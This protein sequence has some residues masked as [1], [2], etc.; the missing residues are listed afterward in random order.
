LKIKRIIVSEV[1]PFEISKHAVL[2][3]YKRVK[4]NKGAEG[5]DEQTIVDFEANLKD[6]LYK[7]W[8]R[9]SSGTYFPPAVR[10]VEI[11]KADGKK[12]VLGIPTVGDRV[13][14]TVVKMYLE[15]FVDP[16]FHPNSYGYRPNKSATDAVG[17][18][19]KRCWAYDW[20]IDIDIKGFF[21]NMDHELVMRAVMK[22]TESK[23]IIMY[24][25]RWLKAPAMQEDGTTI[26]RTKGSPQGGVISPLIANIFMHHVFDEW[27][28]SNHSVNLFERYADDSA[29]RMPLGNAA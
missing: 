8:N 13:A 9:M 23:W 7:I 24:I 5:I 21:D 10:M 14:Q 22:H 20:I 2:E 12:R 27:M 1:K 25:E 29:T 26:Q 3:A 4:A 16:C 11:P 17:T 18:A 6:N 28:K 15:P 19:R